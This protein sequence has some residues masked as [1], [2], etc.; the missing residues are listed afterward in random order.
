MWEDVGIVRTPSG[1][2]EGAQHLVDLADRSTRLFETSALSP[3]TVDLRSATQT[4]AVI[5]AA[6]LNNPHSVGAHY[7][8]ANDYSE[9]ELPSA[10]HA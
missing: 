9:D 5:A 3:A 8:E 1:M 10:T 7:V 4:G 6:A 2:E